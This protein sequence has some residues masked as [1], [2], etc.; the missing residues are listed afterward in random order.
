MAGSTPPPQTPNPADPTNSVAGPYVPSHIQ[1]GQGGQAPVSVQMNTDQR[2]NTLFNPALTAKDA[3][4]KGAF[5]GPTFQDFTDHNPNPVP[6]G[7]SFKDAF[8]SSDPKIRNAVQGTM[9]QN[10]YKDPFFKAEGA[11]TIDTPYEDAKRFD[12]NLGFSPLRNNESVYA[13]N[14]GAFSMMGNALVNFVGKTASYAA[15]SVGLMGGAIAAVPTHDITNMTDNFVTRAADWLKDKTEQDFPIYK[16]DKYTNGNIFQ[17][18]GT[19]GWWMDDAMD[20]VALTAAMFIPGI[21]ES[22]GF[23]LAGQIGA[24][25]IATGMGAKAIQGIAN[26]E[27]G[28]GD[29]MKTFLPK[30]AK[31][32]SEGTVDL[33]TSPALKSY[34][35]TLSKG[36]MGAWNIVGQ[37]GLN[38]KESYEAVYKATND[39]EKAADAAV[40]SFWETLPLSMT[41]TLIELPQMFSTVKTAKS[42]LSKMVD[43]ETGMV[44]KDLLA[45]ATKPASILKTGVKSILTGIEHGQN[46]SMQ[47]AIGRYNEESAEGK[48][49][50]GMIK[51][52]LGDFLDNINDPNGQNNIALGT[53]QGMLTTIIGKGIGKINPKSPDNIRNAQMNNLYNIIQQAQLE[54]RFNNGDFAARNDDGSIKTDAQGKVVYDQQKL[55]QAGA[56][57]AGVQTNLQ[58]KADAIRS[59]DNVTAALADHRSLSGLAEAYFQD[60]AGIHHLINLLQIESKSAMLD[61]NRQNDVDP[62]DNEITPAVQLQQRIDTVRQLKKAY[63]AIDERHGGM[64]NLEVDPNNTPQRKQ[65]AAFI[66]Q[67]KHAQYVEASRQI[68]L[69]KQLEDNQDAMAS[70]RLT[71]DENRL[72]EGYIKDPVNPD[73]QKHNQL[74]YNNTELKEALEQ[75]RKRYKTII[76]KDAQRKAFKDSLNAQQQVAAQ[77]ART[78]TQQQA[79]QNA[80]QTQNTNPPAGNQSTGTTQPAQQSTAQP[81]PIVQQQGNQTGQNS[82]VQ[83]ATNPLTQQP[84]NITPQSAALAAQPVPPVGAAAATQN[85]PDAGGSQGQPAAQAAQAPDQLAKPGTPVENDYANGSNPAFDFAVKYLYSQ[86]GDN[87]KKVIITLKGGIKFKEQGSVAPVPVNGKYQTFENGKAKIYGELISH[88]GGEFSMSANQLSDQAEKVEVL[89]ETTGKSRTIY[90]AFNDNFAQGSGTSAVEDAASEIPGIPPIQEPGQTE[91]D[92]MDHIQSVQQTLNE[93]NTEYGKMI[94]NSL[95]I[96]SKATEYDPQTGIAPKDDDGRPRFNYNQDSIIDFGHVVPGSVIY[97]SWNGTEIDPDG[98]PAIRI[99]SNGLTRNSIV[100]LGYLHTEKGARRLLTQNVDVDQEIIKLNAL[101]QLVISKPGVAFHAVVSQTGFGFANKG[102]NRG[103]KTI[104]EATGDDQKAIIAV[105]K[106]DS[107]VGEGG[108]VVASRFGAAIKEGSVVLM[109]PNNVNG[110]DALIP[111]YIAKKPVGLDPAA[112]AIVSSAITAFLNSGDEKDL[113]TARDYV[114]ITKSGSL[115][116]G[117]T[118]NGLFLNASS[119]LI[120]RGQDVSGMNMDDLLGRLLINVNENKL[121]DLR[122]VKTLRES[123]SI[124]TTFF[125]RTRPDTEN[126]SYFHQHTIQF[127]DPVNSNS[128]IQTQN[129]EV[130]SQGREG[131]RAQ[132][133]QPKQSSQETQPA[134]TGNESQ[135]GTPNADNPGIP[136]TAIQEGRKD[137]E[138][139]SQEGVTPPSISFKIEPFGRSIDNIDVQKGGKSIGYVQISKSDKTKILTVTGIELKE[140]GNGQTVYQQL[141]QQYP[142]YTIKSDKENLSD[143]AVHMWDALVRKGLA[144]K[145][146]EKQ[147]TLKPKQGQVQAIQSTDRGELE[148]KINRYQSIANRLEAAQRGQITDQS[149]IEKIGADLLREPELVGMLSPIWRERAAKGGYSEKY[150]IVNQAVF[151]GEDFFRDGLKVKIDALKKQLGEDTTVPFIP[152]PV[153]QKSPADLIRETKVVP[154]NLPAGE[155]TIHPV[156]FLRTMEFGDREGTEETKQAAQEIKNAFSQGDVRI[157]GKGGE[158]ADE[159]K[160][161]TISGITQVLDKAP[162]NTIVLTHSSVLKGIKV[163]NELGRPDLARIQKGGDLFNEYNRFYNNTET[164]TG[165]SYMMSGKNGRIFV[166]RHGQTQDNAAG[167]FRSR[168]TQLTARGIQEAKDTGEKIRKF[169]NDH[170]QESPLIITSDL[171]RTQHSAQLIKDEVD[172]NAEQDRLNELNQQLLRD[173]EDD[174][175]IVDDIPDSFELSEGAISSVAAQES[176]IVLKGF[177]AFIQEDAINSVAQLLISDQFDRKGLATTLLGTPAAN[178]DQT[179]VSMKQE[180]AK[181]QDRAAK[182]QE[183]AAQGNPQALRIQQTARNLQLVVDNFDALHRMATEKLAKIGITPDEQGY[184]HSV[185]DDP[186]TDFNDFDDDSEYTT[187]HYDSLSRMVKQFI[188]FNSEKVEKDG[189]V[190]NK[191]NSIGLPTIVQPA[192]VYTKVINWLSEHYFAPTYEGF[193]DMVDKLQDIPDPTIRDIAGRLRVSP[194]KQLQFQFFSAMLKFKTNHVQQTVTIDNQGVNAKNIRANNNQLARVVEQQLSDEFLKTSKVL[195]RNQDAYGNTVYRVDKTQVQPYL[196]DFMTVVRSGASYNSRMD[197]NGQSTGVRYLKN[198]SADKLYGILKD[199]GFNMSREGFLRA[200]S[201]QTSTNPKGDVRIG[202]DALFTG[203]NK[204]LR[205][206]AE[207]EGESE[208]RDMRNPFVFNPTEIGAL[209]RAESNFRTINQTDSFRSNGKSY[210]PFTRLSF[211][212]SIFQQ[213][214]SYSETSRLSSLLRTF[215]QD[216][217]KSASRFLKRISTDPGFLPGLEFARGTRE[218]GSKS[219]N[220]EVKEMNDKDFVISKLHAFQNMGNDEGLFFSDT[221]S[222]K[223]T[224]FQIRVPK[225]A[226]VVTWNNGTPR[227]DSETIEKVYNYVQGEIRRI[228]KVRQHNQTLPNEKRIAGFHDIGN[229]EGIGKYFVVHNYLNEESL[230]PQLARLIYD[231][232][233]SI[234]TDQNAV[235]AIKQAINDNLVRLTQNYQEKLKKYGVFTDSQGNTSSRGLNDARY[236]NK[237]K[238]DGLSDTQKIFAITADY[239]A[240]SALNSMEMLTLTGD[241]ALSPKTQNNSKTGRLNVNGSIRKTL[242]EVSK[243]NAS[244]NAPFDQGIYPRAEYKVGFAKDLKI[245]SEQLAEYKKLLPSQAEGI[246]AGY[247]NGDM[248]DAQEVT[249]VKEHLLREMQMSRISPQEFIQ[250]F[251][252]FDPEHFADSKK[253]LAAMLQ[254]MGI[255]Y[256]LNP[257][258]LEKEIKGRD[259]SG[260][261]NVQKP[262]Q[263]YSRWDTDL[264]MLVETYIKTSSFP[265]VPSL[266]E[267]KDF[268]DILRQMKATGVDRLNFT[269]G[270][271]QGLMNPQS[272]YDENGGVNQNLFN[273]NVI[274]LPAAA[275]GEQL[276]NPGKE[277]LQVTEGSQQQRMIFV[278]LPDDTKL[279]YNGQTITGKELREKYINDH[280]TIFQSKLSEFFQELGINS[281]NGINSFASLSKLSEIL[282]SEGLDRDY[283][284]NTLLALGLNPSGQF[285]I[286]LTFLPN[287]SETQALIAAVISNRILKN[288]LPGASLIQGSEMVIKTNGKVKVSDDISQA[289]KNSIVWTRPEHTNISKLQ[290]IRTENGEV[291][292][293]QI[294]LPF[295]FHTKD[296]K[297]VKLLD[298]TG[299]DNLLDI[300]KIDPEL[301]EI[302]GFRIPYAG[303]NSGMWFEVVGYLPETMGSLVIVPAEVAAQMGA[304]YDVDKLFTYVLNHTIGSNNIRVDSST[305][306]FAAENDIIRA[307]K[308]VYLNKDRLSKTIEPTSTDELGDAV[309]KLPKPT[310]ETTQIYDPSHQDEVWLSNRA[311]QLGVGISANYNTFHAMAQQANLFIKGV[312]VKFKDRNGKVY[313]ETTNT[314]EGNTLSGKVDPETYNYTS[315][316]TQ[317]TALQDHSVTRL[318][319]LDTFPNPY[320]GQVRSIASVINSWLQ[321]SVDNAKLQLLGQGGINKFNF[322]VALTLA[323]HGFD[324]DWIIPFIN[325]PILKEY[326]STIQGTNDKFV[327]DFSADRKGNAIRDLFARY[328][329]KLPKEK[330]ERYDYE[331]YEGVSHDELT[332]GLEVSG[333][334]LNPE[335]AEK[336]LDILKQFLSLEKIGQQTSAISSDTKV[337]VRGLSQSFAEINQQAKD[338]DAIALADIGNTHL[339]R[340]GTVSGVYLNVPG[341]VDDLFNHPDNPLFAYSTPTYQ[342]IGAAIQTLTGKVIDGENLDDVYKEFK[343]FIYTHQSLGLYNDSTVSDV[344]DRLLTKGELARNMLDLQ[345]KY[346]NS[347]LLNQLTQQSKRRDNDPDIIGMQKAADDIATQIKQEWLDFFKSTDSQTLTFINQLTTYALLFGSKEYGV[348][349]LVK[350]IPFEVLKG[351]GFGDKLNGINKQLSQPAPFAN[352]VR[353]YIQHNPDMAK[354]VSRQALPKNTLYQMGDNG[355]TLPIPVQFTLSDPT[356]EY[357]DKNPAYRQISTVSKEG[358]A[359]RQFIRTYVNDDI[360]NALYELQQDGRTYRRID[361]LGNQYVNEYDFHN[362]NVRTIFP[363]KA[364]IQDS[365]KAVQAPSP[366]D[367]PN[368]TPDDITATYQTSQTVNDVLDTIQLRNGNKMDGIS[369]LNYELA[370]ALAGTGTYQIEMVPG[371]AGTRGTTRH[372]GERVDIYPDEIKR[373]AGI[374][375][376]PYEQA[377]QQ[378]ILHESIHVALDKYIHEQTALSADK[379]SPEF[380]RLQKVYD[381]Y[382]RNLITEGPSTFVRGIKDTF[383]QAELFKALTNRFIDNKA[384]RANYQA[385]LKSV[386]SNWDNVKQN[387]NELLSVIYDMQESMKQNSSGEKAN[388]DLVRKNGQTFEAVDNE[389]VAQ[390]VDHLDKEFSR[391]SASLKEKYY[392]YVS[393]LEFNTM[394]MTSPGFMEHLNSVQGSGE[395]KSA[396]QKFKDIIVRIV[397]LFNKGSLLND[398]IDSIMDISRISAQNTIEKDSGLTDTAEKEAPPA[399]PAPWE[400]ETVPVDTAQIA[401]QTIATPNTTQPNSFTFADGITIP[402]DHLNLNAQQRSTLQKMVDHVIKAR[403]G[404]PKYFNLSGFAGCLGYGTKVLMF[405]GTFKEV[406]DVILGDQLMGIDSTPRNVLELKRGIEQM[407]WIHQKSGISYRVNESHIL[408]LRKLTTQRYKRTKTINGKRGYTREVASPRRVDIINISVRD[409]LKQI[410]QP[411][412]SDFKKHAKGY[413]AGRI[414]FEEKITPFD[415]YY[416]GLWLGDGH[417]CSINVIT[418]MEPEIIEYISDRYTVKI[419]KNTSDCPTIRVQSLQNTLNFKDLFGLKR[420]ISLVQKYIPDIFLYNSTE[421]RLQLLAGII[422]TDGH[423]SAKNKY[424]EITSK[425]EVLANQI[426]YLCRSLGFRTKITPKIATCKQ[427]RE[428]EYPVFRITFSPECYIPCLVPRKQ[429]HMNKS[430][431]KDRLSTGISIE[432]DAIDSYYG[433]VLDKDHLFM[434]EDFTVTH[435]TGKSSTVR[436]A[437][438]YLNKK[439]NGNIRF[440]LS[441]PTHKANKVLGRFFRGTLNTDPVT[442][443]SLLGYKAVRDPLTNKFDFVL[444]ENKNRV[445]YRGVLI[446]DEDSFIGQKEFQDIIAAAKQKDAT[447]IFMGDIAQIPPPDGSNRVSP[448]FGIPDGSQLTQ[449][450]RQADGN[451]LAPIYDKVRNN[452]M[453]DSFA[454]LFP[455]VTNINSKGEGIQFISGDYKDTGKLLS[456]AIQAFQSDEF[457]NDKM[458]AKIIAYGNPTIEMYNQGIRRVILTNPEN[459]FQVGELLMGYEQKQQEPSVQ[460]GQDYVIKTSE[461]NDNKYVNKDHRVSG[462]N[463]GLSEADEPLKGTSTFV[464]NANDLGNQSF[465]EHY[466]VLLEELKK[467]KGSDYYRVQERIAELEEGALIPETIYSYN[468]HAYTN[469]ML[470]QQF[471]QLFK[472]DEKTNKRPIDGMTSIAKNIDYG[473]AVTA[474]KAQGSTYKNVYIDENNLEFDKRIISDNSG[475]PFSYERNNLLYVALSRPTTKAVVLSR[476]TESTINTNQASE[477]ELQNTRNISQNM[478]QPTIIP[479]GPVMNVSDVTAMKIKDGR[480]D[481]MNTG[482]LLQEGTYYLKDGTKV[483]VVYQGEMI[484]T[485]GAV[486]ITK[487][488]EAFGKGDFSN[489][490]R[491]PF[492]EYAKREGYSSWAEF[493]KMST[494]SKA[495]FEGDIR[496]SY[497]IKRPESMHDISDIMEQLKKDDL[498]KQHDC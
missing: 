398:A 231:S 317:Q 88:G 233:G 263:R 191:M 335:Q 323:L 353:Q 182:Y 38:A 121:N 346:P 2:L 119:Q 183:L 455:H 420:S 247:K 32:A 133:V 491:I 343:Q 43:P 53:I 103:Y 313:N 287:A 305:P 268:E 326:Y 123:P 444:D 49:T 10:M 307:H 37:S 409:Y 436:F 371:K 489:V 157:G 155:T 164:E 118:N 150:A 330:A 433:F 138:I 244:L 140:K 452:L 478:Q 220:Q 135:R 12:N 440:M 329:G 235:N 6:Q 406:Q 465:I 248:T 494:A 215:V 407:Y 25:G 458:T 357:L 86:K 495:L 496:Y 401:Q 24:D 482:N 184:Y 345:K 107:F 99:N 171:P 122:Y 163:W 14:Q 372:I 339:L 39:K 90:D 385:D 369:Q 243:R 210:Y 68:F 483:Q 41:N 430:D 26:A 58:M 93:E 380:R 238:L 260:M 179:L 295:Y 95:S 417:T 211:V 200:V 267:G 13:R 328:V 474:H 432:K 149:Q 304:D 306:R 354:F 361:T 114:Y 362:P 195:I 177:N 23:S 382:R 161:R 424:Y 104:K 178:K 175:F 393:P 327:K 252:N 341:M 117:L 274:T 224:R 74:Y 426:A 168:N 60:P 189:K 21:A 459:Q 290:Y 356:I 270:T 130:N 213:L 85:S 292:P 322:N 98:Q 446:I 442:T 310:S 97:I 80:T 269:S 282:Q 185:D 9:E 190:G 137:Q 112:K 201:S 226:V 54:R 69:N 388:F 340:T 139:V 457:K 141:Q 283:D 102:D 464:L 35:Q 490:T 8:F 456:V 89:D 280:R 203:G 228:N 127:S 214:K 450:M 413:Q 217:F 236:Y 221:Y 308:A 277:E 116:L 315:G 27:G 370:K 439:F 110:T 204:I 167:N 275:W 404:G 202:L 143:D 87:T 81:G 120:Y 376:V 206:M 170:N 31:A 286:P 40:K 29:V 453:T 381:D 253:E 132:N 181:L 208:E 222:D 437:V 492:E 462:W 360:G 154:D 367:N 219:R 399:E 325:Q 205:N 359:Y 397:S 194:N 229:K 415:P 245:N 4:G 358:N 262:V 75:S 44:S 365:D 497:H 94:V 52:I 271:K 259:M 230:N 449:V 250:A 451:P 115:A 272:L 421:K 166:V 51:G 337:E 153:V 197:Q 152:T 411:G 294:V 374:L 334:T 336:Q 314:D 400:G 256:T 448:A 387:P 419:G 92:N 20:R 108:N 78:T 209:A 321:A 477:G 288:K 63:D 91:K 160:S 234:M 67:L 300:S 218:T 301:L 311:G 48:D 11:N 480:K 64:I 237:L 151:S 73:E 193:Q 338:I 176:S 348:S 199:L 281:D 196:N 240:N 438:E 332:T 83:P 258:E 125:A 431:F 461:Y 460:N 331:N 77:A 416:F 466:V 61:T 232:N 309:D 131:Q 84:G 45:E 366:A 242:T 264:G 5:Q 299:K 391:N 28:F 71:P 487:D 472:F 255:Q 289:P 481:V 145:E 469:S 128:Q 498:L 488:P 82:P 410:V 144:I 386:F 408:S 363:L 278:D 106:G 383:L 423:F 212:K 414:Q 70:L 454:T 246:D 254:Q 180:L 174:G 105:K 392:A 279:N 62:S 352:F 347:I 475:K 428:D 79:A 142:Q 159:F 429:Y 241:P 56:S 351:I 379:Q 216:P 394:A 355:K 493:N 377:L 344:K 158:T 476:H 172:P 467:S 349:N 265:L 129:G 101:R 396:W 389:R 18:L 146:G 390:I 59:G 17:K 435:N 425:H 57:L 316:D 36:E 434:L 198:D 227:F 297:A 225:E 34:V 169:L 486:Y 342:Q 402:T 285:E 46:E 22:K 165:D 318:D 378:T 320:S 257:A 109:L 72:D 76:D 187:S 364:A 113:N 47:V 162:D 126:K 42:L 33:G 1:T 473:Y 302:N 249:T 30:L 443:K 368:P 319:R 427:C 96:A 418:N 16:S 445:P 192:V 470:R 403:E 148:G 296:G 124:Q 276:S 395:T 3:F 373:V 111:T 223:T 188:A 479:S 273:N 15:Q 350:Y 19:F 293:A 66:E 324:S 239:L 261:L 405:N 485:N 484:A 55:A 207:G 312:G 384:G 441:T 50:R 468:G 156:S 422:D 147:Y 412:Q 463:L 333:D 251:Y 173:M 284:R 65:A 266:V 471:P 134:E 136:A 298:Y 291:K 375:K 7:M 447:V 100:Q 303:P 186:N